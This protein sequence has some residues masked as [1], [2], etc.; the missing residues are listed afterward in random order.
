MS[1][2]IPNGYIP[3]GNTWENFLSERI[4]GTRSNF[5]FNSLPRE[6]PRGKNDDQIPG[7]EQNFSELE[8]TAP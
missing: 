1:Q 4:P 6:L 7:V 5:L 2:S 8:E 3:P